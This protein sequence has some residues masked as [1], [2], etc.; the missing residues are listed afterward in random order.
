MKL[1]GSYQKFKSETTA[2]ATA[3]I[4]TWHIGIDWMISGPHGVRAAYSKAGETKGPVGTAFSTRPTVNA[5]GGTA[6][7]MWQ[8]RYVHALSK[9]TE[10]TAGFSRTNNRANANYETGGATTTQFAGSDSNAWALA[11]QHRF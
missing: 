9:R 11:V 7:D 2:T 5:A 8:I 4:S 6:A 1:G 10:L 3:K